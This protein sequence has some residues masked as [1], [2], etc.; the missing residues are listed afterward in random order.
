MV[1]CDF[2]FFVF[3]GSSMPCSTYPDA[4]VVKKWK[5]SDK[6][7][8]SMTLTRRKITSTDKYWFRFFS[9]FYFG[10]LFLEF[11]LRLFFPV[12][13]SRWNFLC[14]FTCALCYFCSILNLLRGIGNCWC[15]R[16]HNKVAFFHLILGMSQTQRAK[17]TTKRITNARFL[18]ELAMGLPL[19]GYWTKNETFE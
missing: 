18:P 9:E 14:I 2:R 3:L 19:D 12:K 8:V 17:P 11:L 6:N 4:L 5:K 7:W 10:I 13:R 1:F 15:I 16:M